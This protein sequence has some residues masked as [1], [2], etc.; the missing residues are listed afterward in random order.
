[1]SAVT[2]N[3]RRTLTRTL[4]KVPIM[5]SR[6]ARGLKRTTLGV[7]ALVSMAVGLPSPCGAAVAPHALVSQLTCASPYVPMYHIDGLSQLR[8]WSYSSPANGA[9]TWTQQQIGTGWGTLTVFPGGSGV[10]FAVDSQANLRWYLDTGFGGTG[11]AAWGTGTGSIVGTG[12][13]GFTTLTSG[14]QG[15]VYGI[16][17][18]GNLRWYR[19]TGTN[20]SAS[21]A[22]GSGAVIGTG[23]NGLKL[24]ASG[25]GVIYAVNSSGALFWYRHL[26]P[27]GGTSSWAN[28]GTAQQIGTGWTFTATGSMGGGVLLGR[29]SAGGLWW[30]RHTDPLAGAATWAN[31]G[32]AISLGVGWAPGAVAADVN[33]CVA[34]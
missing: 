21:W 7:S 10:V 15:V 9:G 20:G 27:S 25:S 13:G 31:N 18:S 12:W 1:V 11:G 6:T 2:R 4:A 22:S 16:D 17:A 8:R 34:S 32:V 24:I 14:G 19:Y 3:S 26:D 30:Y 28:N 23:W 29:D 5:R 33:G